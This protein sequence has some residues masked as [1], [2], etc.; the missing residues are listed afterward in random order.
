MERRLERQVRKRAEEQAALEHEQERHYRAERARWNADR[1]FGG[2]EAIWRHSRYEPELRLASDLHSTYDREA[3]QV[4]AAGGGT[5][6]LLAAT[7][8]PTLESAL[9]Q[10]DPVVLA[11]V[12]EKD[13]LERAQLQPVTLGSGPRLRRLVPDAELLR[14][15]AAGEPLRALASDYTVAHTTLVRFFARAEINRQLRD[16]AEQLRAERRARTARSSAKRRRKRGR[17]GMP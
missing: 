16:T 10:I 9:R 4:V 8:L 11:Q 1:P 13:A 5:R 7:G 17:A 15:R 12:F 14:R 2:A 3:L 6:A